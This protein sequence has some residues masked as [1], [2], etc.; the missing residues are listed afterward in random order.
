MADCISVLSLLRRPRLLIRAARF[1]LPEYDRRRDLRRILGA[2]PPEGVRATLAW[3]I[4]REAAAEARRQDGD[5]AY[6][7]AGHVELLVA[8]MAEARLAQAAAAPA[9]ALPAPQPS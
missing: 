7:V 4:E 6:D 8:L 1:A 2:P 9:P 3:L 5:P